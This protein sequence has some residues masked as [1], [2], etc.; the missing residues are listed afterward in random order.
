MLYKIVGKGLFH[1]ALVAS[2]RRKVSTNGTLHLFDK[3][4]IP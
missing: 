2:V 4:K 3:L 1:E